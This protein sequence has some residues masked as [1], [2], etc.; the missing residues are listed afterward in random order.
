M[1]AD[2]ADDP[3]DE[4]GSWLTNGLIEDN[5]LLRKQVARLAE[6]ADSTQE[7]GFGGRDRPKGRDPSLLWYIWT[8][9]MRHMR[10][11]RPVTFCDM[12][13]SPHVPALQTAAAVLGGSLLK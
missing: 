9:Q 5:A 4:D 10:G 6:R 8:R 2:L 3:Q 7:S 11:P 1:L 13:P 12:A